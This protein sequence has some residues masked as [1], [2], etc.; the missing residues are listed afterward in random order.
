MDCLCRKRKKTNI[1]IGFC[2]LSQHLKKTM[3]AKVSQGDNTTNLHVKHKAETG[4][5]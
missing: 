3:S 5:L 4:H 1:L 2:L